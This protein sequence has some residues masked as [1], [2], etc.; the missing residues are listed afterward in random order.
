[1]STAKSMAVLEERHAYLIR[2]FEETRSSYVIAEAVAVEHALDA[3][4]EKLLR[5]RQARAARH[6]MLQHLPEASC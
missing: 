2:K 5:D 6:T 3:L 1:M 4:A